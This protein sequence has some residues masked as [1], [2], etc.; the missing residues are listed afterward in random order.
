MA[1]LGADEAQRIV[2][3]VGSVFGQSYTVRVYES[4]ADYKAKSGNES[5]SY[6]WFN[7]KIMRVLLSTRGIPGL[8]NQDIEFPAEAIVSITA[9]EVGHLVIGPKSNL[10][11]YASMRLLMKRKNVGQEAL[12]GGAINNQVTDLAINRHMGADDNLAR[13]FGAGAFER[14][15]LIV[16]RAGGWAG[17]EPAVKAGSVTRFGSPPYDPGV[18][19]EKFSACSRAASTILFA[20]SRARSAPEVWRIRRPSRACESAC[21]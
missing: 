1:L 19:F 21:A 4:G 5:P 8:P 7:Q 11:G 12:M 20:S 18:A 16:F 9:H 10:A 17:V 2:T 6:G 15:R 13:K 3:G 14:G